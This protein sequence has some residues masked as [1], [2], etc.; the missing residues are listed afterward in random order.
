MNASDRIHLR[1]LDSALLSLVSERARFLA[2]AGHS[3]QSSSAKVPEDLLR[4]YEGP[5]SADSIA[6]LFAAVEKACGREDT[7]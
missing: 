6:E 3:A 4:R 7:P 1:A 2:A 5:L